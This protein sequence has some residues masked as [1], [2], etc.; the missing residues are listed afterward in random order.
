LVVT[1]SSEEDFVAHDSIIAT[2]C[3]AGE[4]SLRCYWDFT[5]CRW[6]CRPAGAE[7]TTFEVSLEAEPPVIAPTGAPTPA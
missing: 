5:E 6:V 7:R 3:A 1:G 4:H 2:G